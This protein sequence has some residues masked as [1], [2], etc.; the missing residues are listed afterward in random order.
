VVAVGSWPSAI[1]IDSSNVYWSDD[2]LGTIMS[3][4][5]GGGG[6][7]TRATGQG[8]SAWIVTDATSLYWAGGSEIMRADLHGGAPSPFVAADASALARDTSYLYWS[9]ASPGAVRRAALDGGA[10][11]LLLSRPSAP[12]EVAVDDAAIFWGEA[13]VNG[14]IQVL[15][16]ALDG[17]AAPVVVA[18]QAGCF[19]VSG[20]RVYGWTG[21][22]SA[23][24]TAPVDGGA[25]THL[26]DVSPHGDS[27]IPSC[28]A[29]DETDIY[30]GTGDHFADPVTLMKMPLDG[31]TPTAIATGTTPNI[32]AVSPM[33]LYWTDAFAGRVLR[34]FR[35]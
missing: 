27:F 25:P 24:W 9:E 14:G 29:V 33:G 4:P 31:G 19:V 7:V 20:G 22:Y 6:V 12:F 1:A 16:Q 26:V 13:N 18:A 3:A 21:D 5:L 23:I 8:K 32:A 30:W 34:T 11:T 2:T 15:R 28:L 35:P 17:S 10:P